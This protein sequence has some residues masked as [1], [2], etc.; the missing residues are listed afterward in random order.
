RWLLGANYARDRIEDQPLELFSDND[1]GHL[2]EA[3]DPEAF[4]DKSLFK[5]D[6]HVHTYAAFGRL[7]YNLTGSLMLEGAIRYNV[8]RRSF[9]SCGFAVSDHF[10]RF[11]NLF[12]GGAQPPTRI[13]DCF[14]LDP[15]NAWQPVGNVHNTLNQDS[16]S[17]RV[18]LNWTARSGVL[19]YA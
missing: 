14:V 18:G 2:F 16:L 6:T 4:A 12:R 9:D 11:W 5:G 13:G 8:D 10:A 3:L 1:V 15:A 19:L 17:W 7:E